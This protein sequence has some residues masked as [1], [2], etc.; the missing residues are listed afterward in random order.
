MAPRVLLLRRDLGHSFGRDEPELQPRSPRL[1][2]G[3]VVRMEIKVLPSGQRPVLKGLL[4]IP[5]SVEHV[6]A[7]E[8]KHLVDI[9]ICVG[10]VLRLAGPRRLSV[11]PSVCWVAALAPMPAAIELLLV[12]LF[13]AVSASD[14]AASIAP[15]LIPLLLLAVTAFYKWL[16]VALPVSMRVLIVHGCTPN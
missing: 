2:S 7:H 15:V 9:D 4:L 13:P 16:V 1:A 6:V 3:S 14:M 8:T 5:G 11:R 12:S 10:Q